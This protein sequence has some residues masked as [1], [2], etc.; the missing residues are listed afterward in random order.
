MKLSNYHNNAF[1]LKEII[2]CTC[3]SKNIV[4]Y[5]GK[6]YITHTNTTKRKTGTFFFLLRCINPKIKN[7]FHTWANTNYTVQ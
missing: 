7:P 1:G 4:L 6:K 2:Y 3:T 5:R